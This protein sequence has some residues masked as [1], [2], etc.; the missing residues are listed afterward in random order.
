MIPLE[1]M[2][3]KDLLDHIADGVYFVDRDRTI[4]Y[5]NHGAERLTGYSS[6]AVVGKRCQDDLLCHVDGSGTRLCYDGCPL[7]ATICDGKGHE[8]A[9]FLRRKEGRR[10]PVWVR[11]QPLFDSDGLIVG[12][13]EIFTD[14][15][16]QAEAHRRMKELEK[17]AFLDQLTGL[18]NRRFMDIALQTALNEFQLHQ[19]SFG[20]IC[21][22]LDRFKEINDGYGH[23]VG[24]L[25]LKETAQ[26]LKNAIRST[27]SV[28]RW[29]GDEFTAIVHYAHDGLLATIAERCVTLVREV[30]IHLGDGRKL[31]TS[32]SVGATLARLEDRIEDLLHRAD[33]QLYRS[34]S[35]GRSCA[36]IS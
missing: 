19:Q 25:V 6:E 7:T 28:G 20:V 12:G 27:D 10:V 9:V 11:V 5:W 34:K 14:N 1:P 4:T 24:D 8:A 13:V 29:G 33:E 31:S 3:Y 26:T 15:T 36:S 30:A 17:M 22:D 32:V 18:P 35:S 16:A 2:F 21:I 23:A